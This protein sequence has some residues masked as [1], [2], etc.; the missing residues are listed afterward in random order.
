MTGPTFLQEFSLK[1]F[2]N[3]N[4]ITISPESTVHDAIVL[5]N[6]FNINCLPILDGSAID[7]IV[8]SISILAEFSKNPYVATLY[9]KIKDIPFKKVPSFDENDDILKVLNYLIDTNL[10]A[11][12]V[13]ENILLVSINPR[14]I[15]EK[16]FLWTT[17][18]ERI[19]SPNSQGN[20]LITDHEHTIS[21][22]TSLLNLMM[23]ISKQNLNFLV[24]I[25]PDT[26]L[27]KGILSPREI[28]QEIVR[29]TAWSETT[30]DF[31][32][33][34]ALFTLPHHPNLY[35]S[36]M[37]K[38]KRIRQTMVINELS[39]MPL[40]N[41]DGELVDVVHEIDLLRKLTE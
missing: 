15:L 34:K 7:G 2:A 10:D 3:K 19:Y 30:E 39:L 4:V 36:N 8:D 38:I 22:D 40:V 12:I 29:M 33:R 27:W 24:L 41:N 37:P 9:T 6:D 21:E 11:L 35:F 5:I 18:D 1:Q 28:I 25:E 26:K 31:L 13:S 23:R 17:L 16:D 20:L 32:Y 14:D